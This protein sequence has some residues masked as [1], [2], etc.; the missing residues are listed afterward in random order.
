M[1][2]GKR[3]LWQGRVKDLGRWPEVI[4]A[5]DRNRPV[6]Y[7]EGDA[8]SGPDDLPP[9]PEL[10]AYVANFYRVEAND[11]K[12][13]HLNIDSTAIPVPTC[14]NLIVVAAQARAVSVR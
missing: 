2:P 3:A 7:I 14:I 4:A 5:L 12:L 9:F 8:G 13:Y 6:Y 10:T 1:A 11:A